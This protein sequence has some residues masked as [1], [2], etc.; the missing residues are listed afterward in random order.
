MTIRKKLLMLL[1]VAGL[2]ILLQGAYG[3][4][5][6]H[7]MSAQLSHDLNAS[8]ATGALVSGVAQAQINFKT[9]V[10]E[11][12][13]ILIRGNDK[14]LFDK[15]LKGFS[16]EEA[17]VVKALEGVVRG[18]PAMQ[19]DATPAQKTLGE[20]K[21]LGEKYRAA[22]QM[23]DAADPESGKKVDIAVRGMD[24]P[25][26][27][28]LGELEESIGK[29]A[30]EEAAEHVAEGAAMARSATVWMVSGAVLVLLAVSL[31]GWM[32][33]NSIMTPVAALRQTV[34][35]IEQDWDLTLRVPQRGQDELAQCGL[36]LN[37]MLERFQSIVKDIYTQSES[38][39]M[40]SGSIASALSQVGRSAEV[41]SSSASSVAAAV[42]ELTVSVT[43]VGDAAQEAQHLAGSSLSSAET[44]RRAVQQGNEQLQRTSVRVNETAQ[45]LEELG[46]RSTAI[47]GIVQTVKEI[48]DQTN[49]LA[50]NAAIEAAR[51]GE[52]GRGFAV[53][54]DEVRKL[55]ENTTRSTE[56]INDLV[57][58]IQASSAKAIS[59]VRGV[60]EEFG[61]Q[62]ALAQQADTA[63]SEIRTAADQTSEV[64]ARI[65]EALREQS[66]ASQLIA[67]QVEQIAHMCEQNNRAVVDVDRSTQVLNG[68][69]DGLEQTVKRF[70]I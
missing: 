36:A 1:L 48:A 58:L 10:Q 6:L 9:Q 22:L 42:E 7:Q 5:R 29:F 17:K 68:L 33:M 14:A 46:A 59:D 18:M 21:T 55:A 61:G 47:S 25:M 50:L 54:A 39:A 34:L 49:L 26:A 3:L 20:L 31:G 35:R 52:Q 27:T 12:K 16:D 67:Q 15:H 19:M 37:K 57:K 28:A 32:L 41:Q 69:A 70:R 38:L 56:Q 65:N 23:F 8:L 24:K 64:S 63:I 51:A 30:R 11:W 62:L 53:V 13:N 66:A 40:Q 4:Q 2:A 45:A 43:Q 44:G 60:V